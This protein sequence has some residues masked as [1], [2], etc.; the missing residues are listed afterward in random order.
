MQ[1]FLLKK[2]TKLD[3]KNFEL[4]SGTLQS[5]SLSGWTT[6]YAGILLTADVAQFPLEMCIFKHKNL[7]QL[8]YDY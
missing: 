3:K 8:Q 5:W 6:A 1:L 7:L 2:E 4:T